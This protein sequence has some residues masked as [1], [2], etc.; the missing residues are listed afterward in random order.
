[1]TFDEA[2]AILGVGVEAGEDGARRAYL[3]LVRVHK[4]DRDPEGFR[5]VREAW[6]RVRP[7][8]AFRAQLF[9]PAV[10]SEP[11]VTGE[12]DAWVD[13]EDDDEDE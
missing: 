5:R 8:I 13:E 3:R 9:R 2:M 12:A 1:M 6:E 10:P 4:P 11:P 7:E